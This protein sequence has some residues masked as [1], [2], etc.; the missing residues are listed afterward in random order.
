MYKK[1]TFV[2]LLIFLFAAGN[3]AKAQDNQETGRPDVP[4]EF[5][6][7][8]GFNFFQDNDLDTLD[9]GFWG[10]KV[11]NLSYLFE[12]KLTENIYFMPGIGLSLNKFK[13]DNDVTLATSFNNPDTVLVVGI[14]E[15]ID[16]RIEI[17]KTKL[18]VNYVEVP[19]ELRYYS[20][21]LD[22]TSSFN[23]GI[24]GK[25][26]FMYSAHTKVNYKFDDNLN[27][28]KE[29]KDFNLSRWSYGALARIGYGSFGLYG[30][31][32]LNQLFEEGNG[33][34]GTDVQTFSVGLTIV[35]F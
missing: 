25:F 5:L 12:I 9:I 28:I 34:A 33:P 30:Y 4:G 7:D 14:S 23:F 24:G 21:P 17:E 29:K 8:L 13:F 11:V 22:K 2:A 15:Y 35:G 18:A 3:T 20:N 10:S 6:I 26:G 19:L 16:E 31:Y 32:S 1:I 27:K